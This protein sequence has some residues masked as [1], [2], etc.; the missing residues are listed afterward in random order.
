M[1]HV[2]FICSKYFEFWLLLEQQIASKESQDQNT[3]KTR[4]QFVKNVVDQKN[5]S[6]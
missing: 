1:G 6:N 2:A 5:G 4:I 3:P